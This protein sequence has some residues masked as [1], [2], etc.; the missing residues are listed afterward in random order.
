M[1]GTDST[2]DICGCV[3]VRQNSF[4]TIDN[5]V[6]TVLIFLLAMVYFSI[7]SYNMAS[8]KESRH[9]KAT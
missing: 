2:C 4:S 8:V 9:V 6:D 1:N 5:C 3:S 7:L